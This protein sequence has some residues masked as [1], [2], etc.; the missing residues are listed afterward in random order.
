MESTLD[1]RLRDNADGE[2]VPASAAPATSGAASIDATKHDHGLY[3]R[4]LPPQSATSPSHQHHQLAP[5]HT[6]PLTPYTTSST[7]FSP[8]TPSSTAPTPLP[9]TG[10]V[11]HG[12]HLAQQAQAQAP[13][14][15][16]SS[17]LGDD[18][19]PEAPG[20][21]G[22]DPKKP[23][24]CESCRGLKVRCDPDPADPEGPCKRCAKAGRACVVTQPTRKRQKKTDS[25]VAELEKKIDA[26][27]AS[28]HATRGGGAAGVGGA[29]TG[30]APS[31]GGAGAAGGTVRDDKTGA[32]AGA[33]GLSVMARD[34]AAQAR[35]QGQKPARP[36]AAQSTKASFP[37]IE[38]D[39]KIYQPP[40]VMAG[41]KRK[42]TETRDTTGDDLRDA[43]AALPPSGISPEYSDVVDRGIISMS[44]AGELFAR[45]TE[46]MMEHLP[47]VVFAPEST[48]SEVRKTKPI[49]FLSIMAAAAS[50]MP[51]LQRQ[52]NKELMQII[53]EK[54][55]VVGEKSL[56]L[57]QTIQVATIWYW[58][59]E[60][61]EELKFYS[62][63][64]MAAIMA[65]ELG[66]GRKKQ[67]RAGFRKNML[68]YSWKDSPWKKQP[69]ADPTDI[70]CRRAWLTC[71][72]LAT[73]TSMALHRPNLIRW[74]P[75]TQ[76]CIDILESSPEAA[77]T[78][79]YLCQL[80]WTHKL[81]E[82]VGVQFSMDDPEANINI[83]DP[84]TQYALKG[85]ERE[86]ERHSASI[87]AE[88]QQREY[89][90]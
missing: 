18:G 75:F 47:G 24:A 54:V 3:Q 28:L 90:V 69:P 83:A 14:H 68:P 38:L 51:V 82:D 13:Y 35:D 87:P 84:R 77:P 46:R 71:Y 72:F 45:Y 34:W 27:T 44:L 60:H 49:L 61:F 40:M 4:P 6:N 23:R 89:C 48:V 55:V 1:P 67:N 86:L 22:H 76:E 59:P 56:E 58:P 53:A 11:N 31:T 70:E 62:L 66:L 17:G 2:V 30:N 25:R 33:Y 73:N 21:D 42:F 65:I 20:P 39:P 19:T 29:P 10:H 88:L 74:T 64:H 78:D 9:A 15:A 12:H 7:A 79:K 16:D 43:T 26:L 5:G 52:L 57:V 80:V 81:S 36:P 50:E 32:S 37:P 63:V 85:F 41:Q 8:R